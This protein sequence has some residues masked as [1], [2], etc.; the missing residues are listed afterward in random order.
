MQAETAARLLDDLRREIASPAQHAAFEIP[1]DRYRSDAQLGK[2]RSLFAK[3]PRIA[4]ASASLVPNSCQPYDAAGQ[5]LLL[6]RD[7]AGTARAFY[8]ACRHR[9]TRLVD[10]PCAAKAIVCPYHGWT[11][12]LDG[13]LCHVPHEQAFGGVDLVMRGLAPAPVT[14]R[15][16][17][18]WT[19]AT[20]I[21]GYLGPLDADF[22][23]LGLD[24]HVAWKTARTTRRCNWKLVIEAFLDGY[25]LRVLHRDSIYRFFIDAASVAERAG[26]HVRAMTARRALRDQTTGG[27]PRLLATPSFSLFPGTTVIV[28]PDFVSIVTV[29]PL[30]TDLTEYEHLML[31]PADRTGEAEHWDKSWA[32]IEDTVFASEDLWICEQ[33][34]RGIAAGATDALLFGALEHAV[35]WFHDSIDRG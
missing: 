3:A 5:S 33:I 34:Q 30:A 32:L 18:L 25:H 16:G 31:I 6:V 19:G 15:H 12:G 17:L 27:D 22:A 1:V 20:D 29:Y 14:E 9:G 10:A 28:H 11:Y 8:N 23:A 7:A 35:R 4:L 2:E 26:D 13:A 21:A 24:G